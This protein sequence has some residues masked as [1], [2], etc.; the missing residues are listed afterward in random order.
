MTKETNN[1]KS[2]GEIRLDFSFESIPDDKDKRQSYIYDLKSS[3][4]RLINELENLKNDNNSNLSNESKRS[5]SLA[6]TYYETASMYAVKSLF[7]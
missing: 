1:K 2:L 4:A 7:K 5:I 6:Q 3:A